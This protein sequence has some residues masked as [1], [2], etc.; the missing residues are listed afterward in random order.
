MVYISTAKLTRLGCSSGVG[1][2]TNIGYLFSQ[3][4]RA[5]RYHLARPTEPGNGHANTVSWDHLMTFQPLSYPGFI[6]GY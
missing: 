3:T 5:L 1:V 6:L 2:A 4:E